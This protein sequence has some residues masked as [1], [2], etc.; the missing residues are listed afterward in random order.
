[1]DA[2]VAEL[3][4][5]STRE[6]AVHDARNDLWELRFRAVEAGRDRSREII[7]TSR[8]DRR[9]GDIRYNPAGRVLRDWYFH[10]YL[11]TLRD[12]LGDPAITIDAQQVE[13]TAAL[14]RRVRRSTGLNALRAVGVVRNTA[15]DDAAH[16]AADVVD[17]LT[18]VGMRR[19]VLHAPDGR[20]DGDQ[21]AIHVTRHWYHHCYDDHIHGATRTRQPLADITD[22]QEHAV[23]R[24]LAT[25]EVRRI[26]GDDGIP[27]VTAHGTILTQLDRDLAAGLT[28]LVSPLTSDQQISDPNTIL[29]RRISRTWTDL[30]DDER[31]L[32]LSRAGVHHTPAHTGW[33]N[34]PGEAQTTVLRLYLDAHR[35]EQ[36]A[37][38]FTGT[39]IDGDPRTTAMSMFNHQMALDTPEPADDVQA[40]EARAAVGEDHITLTAGQTRTVGR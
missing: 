5:Q 16:A 39:R 35:P 31:A 23:A 37:L 15:V 32:W 10:V 34:L 30:G 22:G 36:L 4:A 6:Q 1:M 14:L 2:S 27:L 21:V 8:I 11:N 33:S 7:K 26:I 20:F 38:P 13:N 29:S 24:T 28:G 3:V 9:T 19:A 40:D 12:R 17:H 18:G 25:G